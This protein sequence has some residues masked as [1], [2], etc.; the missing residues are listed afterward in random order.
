LLLS[1]EI[2]FSTVPASAVP[3]HINIRL[4]TLNCHRPHDA[5]QPRIQ[6][7]IQLI[8]RSGLPFLLDVAISTSVFSSPVSNSVSPS[9]TMPQLRL[10]RELELGGHEPAFANGQN[11]VLHDPERNDIPTVLPV[12]LF[13]P[14]AR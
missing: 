10:W 5:P 3:P 14:K 12:A 4:L 1:L 9:P 7:F 13:T 8:I 6:H 2:W 11:V